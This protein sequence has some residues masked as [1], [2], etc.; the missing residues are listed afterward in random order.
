MLGR[1][2]LAL[3]I[4]AGV[5][6]CGRIGFD[7]L[8]SAADARP[9]DGKP[10][11]APATTVLFSGFGDGRELALNGVATLAGGIVTLTEAVKNVG[12]SAFLL[13]PVTVT[14]KSEFDIALSFRITP[15]P[16]VVADGITFMCQNAPKADRAVGGNPAMISTVV[17][18]TGES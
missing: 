10:A 3:A 11:D 9:I 6:G 4:L 7:P 1:L 15:G 16:D 14:D 18:R 8:L 13:V 17:F 12:A 2:A 5:D